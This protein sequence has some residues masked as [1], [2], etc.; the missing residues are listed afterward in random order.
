MRETTC[1][2]ISEKPTFL[3]P[4]DGYVT[5]YGFRNESRNLTCTVRAYPV[6][7]F[8]WYKDEKLMEVKK[9]GVKVYNDEN[10]S[11]LEVRVCKST[12]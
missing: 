12:E 10:T 8:V 2:G 9:N 6:A 4:S 5:V 3:Y 7:Y 11:T 1:G